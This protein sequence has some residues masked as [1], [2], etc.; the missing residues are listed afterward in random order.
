MNRVLI[1]QQVTEGVLVQYIGKESWADRLY[2]SGLM[3]EPGQVRRLPGSLAARFL[4]HDDVFQLATDTKEAA[5]AAPVQVLDDTAELLE[6]AAK[7]KAVEDKAQTELQDMLD[8]INQMDKDALQD[9]A[10]EKFG[11]MVPK[12]LSQD[13]MRLKVASFVQAYGV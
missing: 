11:Q 4:R 9:F 13:N 6:Q 8:A 12:N 10:Q 3:F 1:E 7:D 2:S 5:P